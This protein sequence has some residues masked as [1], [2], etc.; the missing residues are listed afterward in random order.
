MRV[1]LRNFFL[2]WLMAAFML[3]GMSAQAGMI[4]TEAIVAA[5]TRDSSLT[6]VNSFMARADVQQQ[7]EAWAVEPTMA[8]ERVAQLS[9]EELQT[10]A[11]NIDAQ[12]AGGVLVV[13]GIV[14]V[15]LLVLE[16]VGVTNIFNRI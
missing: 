5:Q 8:A 9:D 4:G 11:Q 3:T 6:T 7:L 13:L 2:G 15:V 1:S 14:F 12:P 10:L 16:L